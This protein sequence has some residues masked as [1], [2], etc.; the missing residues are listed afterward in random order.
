MSRSR[1][2]GTGLR[3]ALPFSFT[4]LLLPLVVAM[5]LD[6]LPD[7]I[8][9]V[10]PWVILP[11]VPFIKIMETL[12]KD[13]VPNLDRNTPESQVFWHMAILV[14]WAVC[15]PLLVIFILW[16]VCNIPTL[17][18]YERLVLLVFCGM[19]GRL[20]TITSHDLIHRPK[21]WM[22]RLAEFTM[23]AVAMPHMHTEHVYMHHP[24]VA[25][26]RDKE[27]A[28]IGQSYYNYFLTGL[29]YV[30]AESIRLQA[31]RLARRGLPF[32]HKS[33]PVWLWIAMW[34]AWPVMALIIG[35]W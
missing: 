11:L 26:P 6:L 16:A 15:Y 28:R 31:H 23:G 24:H 21:L 5:A 30:Y 13:D 35:G 10:V 2:A 27:S 9:W 7:F 12:R 25:T 3:G 29:P 14:I 8:P 22:R 4:L 19:L 1:T 34:V 33:N 17:L 20:V 32:W 18:I